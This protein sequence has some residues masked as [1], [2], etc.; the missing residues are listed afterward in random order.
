MNKAFGGLNL[1]SLKCTL[2]YRD[3]DMSKGDFEAALWHY[4]GRFLGENIYFL[5]TI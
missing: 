4:I 5:T 2:L 3:W 1:A